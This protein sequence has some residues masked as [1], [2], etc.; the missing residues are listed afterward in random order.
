MTAAAFIPPTPFAAAAA[1]VV[2]LRRRR[3]PFSSVTCVKQQ[4]HLAKDRSAGLRLEAL[5]RFARSPP[6]IRR[7]AARVSLQTTKLH[8]GVLESQPHLPVRRDGTLVLCPLFMQHGR[9]LLQLRGNHP[10]DGS[11]E[12]GLRSARTHGTHVRT[13]SAYLVYNSVMVRFS[14]R[15]EA[16]E[17]S[18][19]CM[20]R[21][22]PA[23]LPDARRRVH[24]ASMFGVGAG[25]TFSS[26]FRDGVHR[27]TTNDRSPRGCGGGDGSF[28]LCL[29]VC[30]H[31]A[32]PISSRF[33]L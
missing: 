12:V 9:A 31:N 4:L 21:S 20:E 24:P 27:S 25:S 29:G 28:E 7:V 5:D 23:V 11:L 3:S 33:L 18:G 10:I 13:A 1:P 15:R 26:L 6:L 32:S 22:A 19:S 8:G 2:G 14:R 30:E 16:A 17:A